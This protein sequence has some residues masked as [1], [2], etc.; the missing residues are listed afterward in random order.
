MKIVIA[1]GGTGGHIF[2][3][4]ALADEFMNSD[5]NNEIIFV[6]SNYRMEKDVITKSR[7]RFIGLDILT[8]SG[9]LFNKAMAAYS[10]VR[11][12]LIIKKILKK[13]K[14]DVCIGFGNYISVPVL[15]AASDLK[16]KTLIHEQNSVAGKANLYLAKIVDEVVGCYDSNLNQF[17]NDNIK[18]YG[19]PRA[20]AASKYQASEDIYQKYD[21]DKGKKILTI[22]MGS[23]GSDSVN[24]V[25]IKALKEVK[26]ENLQIVYIAGAN[27]KDEFNKELGRVLNVKV[28]KFI[29]LIELLSISDLVIS[30]AG[31]TTL[32]EIEALNTPSILI[33]SPY[34]THNHQYLNAKA[35]K[36]KECAEI[37][38]EQDLNSKN[39]ILKIE[40]LLLNEEKLF[41]MRNNLAKYSKNSASYDIINDVIKLVNRS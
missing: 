12:Y 1:T 18:I 35:L 4:L 5:S 22:V 9:N 39:L 41:A 2:P 31:A 37:L 25:M 29:N 40:S 19:N 17:E 3:A 6:G 28:F 16:I 14:V 27:T 21:L 33:P 13:E 38:E 7:Y 20:S 36:D 15:K 10:I 23:L 8:T 24:K 30:R 11:S 26:I 32:A 34:V